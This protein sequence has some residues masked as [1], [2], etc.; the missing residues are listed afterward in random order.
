MEIISLVVGI[1]LGIAIAFSPTLI[2][3]Y[4]ELGMQWIFF[5]APLPIVLVNMNVRTAESLLA[6]YHRG[7]VVG[8]ARVFSMKF[9][10]AY[11]LTCAANVA[12]Y[13]ALGWANG[14]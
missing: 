6:S 13:L 14:H 4:Y 2:A 1:L 3:F 8:A 9:A 11:V 5:L 12:L 10:I 7:G